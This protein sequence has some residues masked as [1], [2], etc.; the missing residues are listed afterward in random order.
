MCLPVQLG[1]TF[2]RGKVSDFELKFDRSIPENAVP[3]I[4]EDNA[5]SNVAI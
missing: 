2:L 1:M 3:S 4:D 5:R